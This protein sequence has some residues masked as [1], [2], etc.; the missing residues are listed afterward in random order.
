M[1]KSAQNDDNFG[2]APIFWPLFLRERLKKFKIALR[3]WNFQARLKNPSELPTKPFFL[4]GT[5]LQV[6]IEIFKRDLRPRRARRGV[7]SPKL[8]QSGQGR[9][10]KVVWSSGAE[11]QKKSLAPVQALFAP[12]QTSFAPVQETFSALPHRSSKQPFALSPDHFGAIWAIWLL[13][14]PAGVVKRDWSSEASH[15]VAR[16]GVP[17]HV[18]NYVSRFMISCLWLL[19]SWSESGFAI[20][21]RPTQT[22]L[23]ISSEVFFS[24]FGPLATVKFRF[25]A[26]RPRTPWAPNNCETP[27]VTQKWLW[28]V[29]PKVSW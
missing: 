28:G 15:G 29:D 25:V 12:V 4:W 8:P 23:K 7:K 17:A 22:R 3:D 19:G 13:S 21:P 26:F 16:Q 20:G 5:L 2:A 27:K 24:R 10:L 1:S 9:V 14:V 18:C 11:V 6:E